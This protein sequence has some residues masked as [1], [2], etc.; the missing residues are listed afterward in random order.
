[1]STRTWTPLDTPNAPPPA[2]AY[3]RCIRAGSLLFISGQVPRDFE[4]GALLGA[5]LEAQTL[6]VIANL[7][8]VLE[9]AGAGLEDVVSVTAY[10]A[11][12]GDWDAFNR[13]YREAFEPPYPTRTTVGAA[14]HDVLVE[15]SAVAVVPE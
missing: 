6:G 13:I 3:S 7:R 9:G 1:M 11:D 14:L 12:I 15:L 2:G 4:T 5:E 8:R 10:L